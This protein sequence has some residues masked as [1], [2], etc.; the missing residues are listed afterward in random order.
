MLLNVDPGEFT[1]FQ[2]IEV[3]QGPVSV[4][5][6]VS[7]PKWCARAN[8]CP[9]HEVWQGADV[10]LKDYLTSVTI[11]DLISGEKA[12]ITSLYSAVGAK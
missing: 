10:L 4:A 11:Q 5:V 2:L 9:F 1:L 8:G 6:C 12:H 3:V 7:D